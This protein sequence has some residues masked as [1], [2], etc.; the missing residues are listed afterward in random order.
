MSAWLLDCP[1][2]KQQFALADVVAKVAAAASTETL[3]RPVKPVFPEAGV[4][5]ECPHCKDASIF[6]SFHLRYQ[7]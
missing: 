4:K 5:L 7:T 6:W 3:E 2:C 1:L